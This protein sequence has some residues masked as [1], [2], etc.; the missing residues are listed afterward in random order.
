[1]RAARRAPAL[2]GRAGAPR[3]IAFLGPPQAVLMDLAGPWDVFNTAN[4]LAGQPVKP[5]A[6]ELLSTSGDLRVETAGGLPLVAHASASAC[7]GPVDTLLVPAA[8]GVDGF[9]ADSDLV[10]QLRR[11]ARRS[12][13]V[14]SVCGGAFV[15]AAA[16]LLDGRRATTHWRGCG[17]LARRYPSVTVEPDRI[18]VKD[19]NVYTSAGV[20]A[21]MDLALALVEED[22]G[23]AV[24]L[25][26]ARTLVLFIRRPGGQTQFSTALESQMAERDALRSLM[27]WAVEHLD[28]DLSVEA[29]AARAHMSARNFSRVFTRE[30]GKTPARYVERLRV[31]AA[32]HLLEDTTTGHGEVARRCGFGGVNS[33]RRSFLRV[34]RIVPSAYRDRFQSERAAE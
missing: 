14:A 3:R 26:V 19:G 31:D 32:R 21:G 15:L 27:A 17:D 11:L 22:L 16:G 20:T 8:F 24:A 5:Y 6:L 30:V 25:A 13:R 12:R 2:P 4:L 29:L 23:R 33:M 7:R 28:E 1:M 9:V 18:F 34:L 10:R